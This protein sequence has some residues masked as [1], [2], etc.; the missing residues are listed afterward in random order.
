MLERYAMG[1]SLHA[2]GQDPH[3]SFSKLKHYALL[4]SRMMR[5]LWIKKFAL[6]DQKSCAIMTKKAYGF[7]YGETVIY[8]FDWGFWTKS[9]L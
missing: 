5:V 9:I 4:R 2:I 6:E 8:Q 1:N 3:I 7:G